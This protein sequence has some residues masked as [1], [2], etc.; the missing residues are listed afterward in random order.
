MSTQLEHSEMVKQLAKP[1]EQIVDQ[2]SDANL[3]MLLIAAEQLVSVG[4]Y[5]DRLKKQAFYNKDSGIAYVG[6]AHELPT[7]IL[8]PD[9]AERLHMAIGVAGE[10]AEL[11]ECT[12]KELTENSFDVDNAIEE[13]GD[14]EFYLNGYRRSIF[15]SRTFTLAHN[16]NKLSTGKKARYPNGYSDAAAQ[17]R[18][19]KA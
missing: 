5:L 18:A 6:K 10:A 1:G 16:L 19:D 7:Y 13:L 12:L 4:N 14:L 17:E 15:V 3:Y 8:T 2:M 11:L 9:R